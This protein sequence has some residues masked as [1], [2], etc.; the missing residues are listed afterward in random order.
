M[1]R[2]GSS[3]AHQ[4]SIGEPPAKT[5]APPGLGGGAEDRYQKRDLFN[6]GHGERRWRN[7]PIQQII[8]CSKMT[9]AEEDG[10]RYACLTSGAGFDGC[11][12]GLRCSK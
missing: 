5:V 6:H 4:G 12:I 2:P 7:D 9:E 3:D 11:L 1:A 10:A 8:D